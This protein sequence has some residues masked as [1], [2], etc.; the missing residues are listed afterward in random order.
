MWRLEDT[1]LVNKTELYATMLSLNSDGKIRD[2][3]TDSVIPGAIIGVNLDLTS[4]GY[5]IELISPEPDLEETPFNEAVPGQLWEKT[6]SKCGE[7]FALK[8]R[9]SG[10]YL[11]ASSSVSSSLKSVFCTLQ[12]KSESNH[13]L[14][15]RWT[16]IFFLPRTSWGLAFNPNNAVQTHSIFV[17]L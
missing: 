7:Y 11:T 8:N 2:I 3:S 12:G 16:D 14:L 1:T 6:P 10:K 17:K 9:A 15:N 4:K 13:G 5:F